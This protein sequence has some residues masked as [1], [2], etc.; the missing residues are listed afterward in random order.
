MGHS[1]A[2]LMDLLVHARLIPT[3][4]DSPENLRRE[5]QSQRLNHSHCT[6]H[7]MVLV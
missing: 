6:V 3:I 7:L 2:L 5:L 4:L 1:S